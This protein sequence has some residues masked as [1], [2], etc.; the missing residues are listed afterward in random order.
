MCQVG[1]KE[2]EAFQAKEA[3]R[4]K[5]NYYKRGRAAALKVRDTVLVCV[6]TFKGHHKIQ[7]R[8]ENREYVVEKQPYPNVPGYVVF[9]RDGKGH[10]QTLHRNY[11][12]PINSGIEQGKMDEPVAGVRNDISLTP[13]PS[14][15]NVPADAGLSGQSHQAW[16]VAHPGV[17]QINLLHLDMA[18]KPPGTNFHGGIEI[19]ICWQILDQLAAGMHRLACVSVYISC[20][21]CIPFSGEVHCKTC[22]TCNII[23]LPSMIHF[24]I[25]G[26]SLKITSKVD[27][28]AEKGVDQRTFGPIAT[29]LPE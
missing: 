19:L 4:H 23:C 2:T 25:Q 14:V 8:W 10:S 9:P 1:S 24:S 12:L 5:C 27:S 28:W 6:T 13:V 17:V 29:P 16:P 20:F 22:P 18:P 15:D 7:D 11:L 26:N 3:Q 21:V